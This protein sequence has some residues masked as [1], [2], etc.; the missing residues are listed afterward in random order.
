MYNDPNDIIS[1]DELCSILS[2]GRNAAYNLLNDKKIK[3]FRIGKVWKV[4]RMAVEDFILT[5]SKLK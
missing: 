2:I 3:A 1:I 5:Q 4:S